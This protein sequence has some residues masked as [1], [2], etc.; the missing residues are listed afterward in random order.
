MSN[1]FICISLCLSVDLI[2]RILKMFE[3]MGLG[4]ISALSA[5]MLY[6]SIS[7]CISPSKLNILEMTQMPFVHCALSV[8]S[9]FRDFSALGALNAFSVLSGLSALSAFSTLRALVHFNV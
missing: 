7:L 6:L 3:S 5:Y 2:L 1:C 8:R 9:A 4:V